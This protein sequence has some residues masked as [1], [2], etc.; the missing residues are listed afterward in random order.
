M[1]YHVR[2][3]DR[4]IT[5]RERVEALLHEGRF[6]TIALVDE[7]GPYA[8]TLSYGYAADAGRLYFHCAAEGRKIDA[9]VADPRAFASVVFDRGYLTGSCEH[10]YQSLVLTGRMRVIEDPSEKIEALRVLCAHQEKATDAFD[11]MGFNIPARVKGV[12]ALAFDIE[13]VTAK[14]GK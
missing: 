12:T 6:C 8:V 1:T 9:I 13:N 14:E 4:E 3:T 11:A 7:G 5:D 10:P 2:R